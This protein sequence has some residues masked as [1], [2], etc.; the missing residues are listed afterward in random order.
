[1]QIVNA[2]KQCG[3]RTV[4]NI[5]WL[6]REE[7]KNIEFPDSVYTVESVSH[8][9]LF[10]QM[11]LVVHHG[12]S[13]TTGAALRAGVPS[14]VKPFF[15]DQF[16]WADRMTKVKKDVDISWELEQQCMI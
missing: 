16:F 4:L 9:W 8:E 12:G 13:G 5:G 1:M 6:S 10:P 7:M 2:I 3:L 15:G 11:K 14:I